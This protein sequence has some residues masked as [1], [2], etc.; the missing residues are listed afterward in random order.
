MAFENLPAALAS[1]AI[2]V[3]IA[4][5][6]FDVIACLR[7]VILGNEAGIPRIK[8]KLSVAALHHFHATRR[9]RGAIDDGKLRDFAAIDAAMRR[10]SVTNDLRVGNA[11]AERA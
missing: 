8:R 4:V 7:T 11:D 9:I 2:A 1:A 6:G 10:S 3:G 5:A